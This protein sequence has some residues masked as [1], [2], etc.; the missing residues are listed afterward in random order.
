MSLTKLQRTLGAF[1][2][3]YI[4]DEGI[5][6]NFVSSEPGRREFVNFKDVSVFHELHEPH[7]V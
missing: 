1:Q 6:D 4:G 2:E 7:I 3:P 5:K